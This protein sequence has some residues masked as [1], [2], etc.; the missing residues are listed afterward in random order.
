MKRFY[1]SLI[2][3]TGLLVIGL[4]TLL[5]AYAQTTSNPTEVA[6]TATFFN[7]TNFGGTGTTVIYDDGLN[8]NYGEGRPTDALGN[9]LL[10][11]NADNFSARFEGTATFA[12]GAYTFT[13]TAD[14]G[15]NLFINDRLV[16]DALGDTNLTTNSATV[17]LSSGSFSLRVEYVELTGTAVVQLTWNIEATTGTVNPSPTPAPLVTARVVQ[18]NGLSLRSGP[19][20]GASFIA[21]ARPDADGFWEN[22]QYPVLARNTQEGI[23][24]WYKLQYDD[25]TVGWSSG[26]YLEITGDE[27]LLPFEGSIFDVVNETPNFDII[28][29]TRSVMNFRVYPSERVGLVPDVFQIPWGAQVEI[30]ARTRQ[31]FQDYWYQVNYRGYVGWIF[32]PFV[33]IERNPAVP[34]DAI[35]IY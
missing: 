10:A 22:G 6:F 1:Q 33:Q 20:L 8:Q 2:V 9:E 7:D 16:I 4:V 27:N 25:D 30:L 12:E 15:A 17:S 14:D 32:A 18:V 35:P 5:P 24:T 23:F 29:T 11:I 31:N 34:I 21:V 19:F 26:R 3:V 13:L 28:G